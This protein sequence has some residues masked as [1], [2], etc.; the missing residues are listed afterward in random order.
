M[1]KGAGASLALLGAP[2]ALAQASGGQTG[3]AA[4]GSTTMQDQTRAQRMQWWHARAS[5]CSFTSGSIARSGG[6]SGSW[7][8]KPSL[9]ASTPLMQRPQASPELG[10]GMGEAGQSGWHEVHGDDDETPRGFLQLRHKID[11][12]LCPQARPRTRPGARVCG[13]SESRRHAC[14]LLLLAYGLAPSRWCAVRHRRGRAPAFRRL[15]ARTSK[16]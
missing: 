13:G 2:G 14:G 9:S 15:H 10:A 6:T 11:D 12:L 16:S 4:S 1:L 7:K 8:M 3:D 5:A